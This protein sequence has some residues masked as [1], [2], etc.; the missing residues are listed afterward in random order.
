MIYLITGGAG[1]IGSHVVRNLLDRGEKVRILDN[2]ATGKR[3]HLVPLEGRVE[4]IEG[5]IRYLNNVQEAVAGADYVIHLA[6]LPSVA[7][8]VRTPIES[9]DTN[10]HGTLNVLIAARDAKVKRVVYAASSSAYGNSATLP[11]VETMPSDPLSPYAVNKL[12]GELYCRVFTRVYGL[13]TVSLRYFNVFGPRQDPSSQ[14]SAVIPR[15]IQSLLA[16]QRPRIFGDGEHSRDFTYV[17]NAVEASLLACTAPGV[18][19]ETINVACGERV[20]LNRLV[21]LICA[22]LGKDLAPIY[23]EPRAGDVLHSQA[24]IRKAQ[25][26]LRYQPAVGMEEGVKRTIEWLRGDGAA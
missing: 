8:S 19:G 2:F 14:Y 3:E 6:A 24:D 4:V 13:E 15:F 20:T 26:L 1:F 16:D 23:D 17:Q 25:T 18:A 22:N 5:D 7:R 11:K 12:A 21:K 10:V 9:N